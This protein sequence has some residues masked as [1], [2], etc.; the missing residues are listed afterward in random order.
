MV[1]KVEFWNVEN[2]Q[3]TWT[4]LKEWFEVTPDGIEI[5]LR[6]VVRREVEKEIFRQ[7]EH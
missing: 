2:N 3:V 6:L 7:V 5:P 4:T 1:L